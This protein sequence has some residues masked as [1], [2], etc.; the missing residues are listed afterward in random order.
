MLPPHSEALGVTVMFNRKITIP[1]LLG[2]TLVLAGCG[3]DDGSAAKSAWG[4]SLEAFCM[5]MNSCDPAPYYHPVRGELVDAEL[6]L[7]VAGYI[8]FY[9]QY[10]TDDC[11]AL[12]AS[13][14][15]CIAAL[16]CGTLPRRYQILSPSVRLSLS[17]VLLELRPDPD[18]EL[19]TCFDET[20][21]E[22][23]RALVLSCASMLPQ[24]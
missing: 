21:R 7:E 5:K 13:Y 16:P 19:Q 3:S 15:N 23:D 10:L 4:A 11:D 2:A 14:Y 22:E 24:P 20:V 17:S 12:Y 6:C 1:N 18:V 9:S 8:D